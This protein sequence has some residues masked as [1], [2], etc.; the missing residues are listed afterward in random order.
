V[1][2]FPAADAALAAELDDALASGAFEAVFQPIARLNDGALAGFEALARWRRADGEL[3]GPDRFLRVAAASDRLRTISR[4]VLARAVEQL[5]RWR[6]LTQSAQGL[7]LSVNISGADLE[8]GDMV[9]E[10]LMLAQAAP[11]PAGALK[12]ELTEHQILKDPDAAA[13]ACTRLR[14]GGIGVALDDF[15]AGF[16][17]LAWLARLPAD[18]LKIDRSFVAAIVKNERAEKIVRAMI[19]LA[20]DLEMDVVCEGVESHDVRERLRDLN[21]DYAQG[22]LFAPALSA[23]GAEALILTLASADPLVSLS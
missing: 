11:L 23:R 7:F 15:G 14:D 12:L 16:A 21:S 2:R 22:H 9:N 20:H 18:T 8:Q 1:S 17:S 13:R 19:L 10:A 5:A 3:W 4:L 6:V